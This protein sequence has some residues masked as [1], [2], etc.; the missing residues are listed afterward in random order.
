MQLVLCLY[1]AVINGRL[2]A[3]DYFE[4]TGALGALGGECM[5]CWLAVREGHE[6]QEFYLD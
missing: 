1:I 2:D 4:V 6:C 3:I 5:A